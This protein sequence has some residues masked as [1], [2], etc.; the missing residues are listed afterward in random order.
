MLLKLPQ[1]QPLVIFVINT[2]NLGLMQKLIYLLPFLILCSCDPGEN[3]KGNSLSHQND[4][5]GVV[6]KDFEIVAHIASEPDGLHPFNNVSLNMI[7]VFE[8]IHRRL[9]RV[10]LK[11]L[12]LIPD[13]ANEMPEQIDSVSFKYTIRPEPT[14]DDGTSLTSEDVRFTMLIAMCPLTNNAQKRMI[15]SDIVDS[16]EIVDNQSLTYYTNYPYAGANHLWNDIPII[17]KKFY[18]PE[19]KL[20][21]LRFG[22][23]K[24]PKHVYSS[25]IKEWFLSFNSRKYSHDPKFI[26]GLGAYKLTD[27]EEEQYLTVKR[28]EDWWGANSTNMYDQ[29]NP[30]IIHYKVISDEQ[31]TNTAILN[32]EIDVAFALSS[33]EAHDLLEN[34]K[35]NENFHFQNVDIFG[36]TFMAINSRPGPTTGNPVLAE[37]EV[38]QAMSL[39]TPYDEILES[40]YNMGSRQVSI[41]CAQRPYYH[42]E[43]ELPALDL[44]KAAE[45]LDQA[46]WIDLNGDGVREKMLNGKPTDLEFEL[47]YIDNPS[48]KTIVDLIAQSYLQVGIKANLKA[49]DAGSM[50]PML[51]AQKFDAFVTSLVPDGGFEDLSQILHTSQ[52]EQKQFNFT[53]FG[54]VTTDSILE[55]INTTFDIT[56]RHDLFRSLQEHFNQQNTFIMLFGVQRKIAISKKFK[57]LECFAEKPSILLHTIE[58]ATDN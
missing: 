21:V 6:D 28:K 32:N 49:T 50:F 24:D 44:K 38:R 15:L 4:S 45:V 12:K 23:F 58:K 46:G 57:N 25:D 8:S 36:M 52:W 26:N 33:V 40:I 7:Y 48:F 34:E 1:V 30:A 10:D 54:N 27:W 47:G 18:D 5:I 51:F 13:L 55:K 39:S 20:D 31:T 29:A 14:W 35:F 11:T 37:T 2:T 19:G 42:H 17:S 16:L 56:E 53:G 3:G 41:V 43:L 22:D 9:F